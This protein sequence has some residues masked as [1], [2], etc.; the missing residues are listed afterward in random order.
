V[1][2]LPKSPDPNYPASIQGY[3][4]EFLGTADN[5]AFY[6]ALREAQEDH[7]ALAAFIAKVANENLP[8]G[9][10]NPVYEEDI[11]L[12]KKEYSS[13]SKKYSQY[14]GEIFRSEYTGG[15]E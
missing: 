9:M 14:A 15:G 13:Y 6:E 5:G 4:T 2:S 7:A 3:F 1:V 10:A 8:D 11:A 12:L